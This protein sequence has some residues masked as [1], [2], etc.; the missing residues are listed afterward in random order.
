V[1]VALRADSWPVPPVFQVIQS[2]GAVSSEEMH[3]VFNMGVGMVLIVAP[4]SVSAV[5]RMLAGRGQ[6]HFQIGTVVS[7]S[8]RV[9][10]EFA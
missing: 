3:R 5:S 1:D 10:I 9:Q 7:G 4:E 8:R 6:R 2:E